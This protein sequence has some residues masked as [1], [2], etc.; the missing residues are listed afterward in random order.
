ILVGQTLGIASRKVLDELQ[1][2][3]EMADTLETI[4]IPDDVVTMNSTVRL[5]NM[6]SSQ[7]MIC[8]IVYPEDVDLIE[9]GIS[10]LETFG[11][12]LIGCEVG[13]L[14]ECEDQRF[15]GSWRVAEI[16]F[17]PERVGKF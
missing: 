2:Q 13:D 4:S 3:L 16:L 9:D 8:T 17:Q 5:V 12:Q 10:V 15:P 14:I 7:E 6:A 1:W 11:T